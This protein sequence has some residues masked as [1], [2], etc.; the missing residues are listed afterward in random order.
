MSTDRKREVERQL[1]DLLVR[2]IDWLKFAEAKNTGSVGLSST[3]LGVIVTFLVAG[4]EI[5][6]LAG[7][8]LAVGALALML[9]LLLTV[10]SFLPST[11]LEK[12]L[13]G[14]R[15]RPTARDNLLYY[16]HL[17]R[18]EP[19]A[20]VEAIAEMYF[21]LEGETYAPS[22]LDIDLAAQIV[23]N[24]RITVRKLALYRY[25]LLL[26]GFGVLVASAAMALASFLV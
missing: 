2:V 16:G 25:S 21:E 22:K 12:H 8:G 13:V 20:L 5:P 26:F 19:R 9:S 3:G 24:A 1:S 6:P 17:A 23:T 10:A 18:Y 11:N 7:I 4:P 15:E 14:E